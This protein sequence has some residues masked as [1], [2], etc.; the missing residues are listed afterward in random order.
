MLSYEKQKKLM[1]ILDWD[2]SDE[3]VEFLN[4][5]YAFR[6]YA[7]ALRLIKSIANISD[8]LV[9]KMAEVSGAYAQAAQWLLFQRKMNVDKEGMYFASMVPVCMAMFPDGT[10]EGRTL[11]EKEYF[12]LFVDLFKDK[13]QFKWAR[14]AE[15]ARTNGYTDYLR[16]VER[17]LERNNSL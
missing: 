12:K 8:T 3:A 16:M 13:K 11:A 1:D 4:N 2:E 7:N 10:A 5:Q 6:N 14:D 9:N 15:W 17:N